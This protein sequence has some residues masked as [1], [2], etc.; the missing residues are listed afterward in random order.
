M[1]QVGWSK[2]HALYSVLPIRSALPMHVVKHPN[3]PG[4]YIETSCIQSLEALEEVS[5]S[6]DEF[7]ECFKSVFCSEGPSG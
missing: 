7:F 6:C 3:P 5:E 1:R 4:I 2:C